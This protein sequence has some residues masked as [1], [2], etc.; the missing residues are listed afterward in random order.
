MK[1]DEGAL[2]LEIV[3]L[4][5]GVARAFLRHSPR[6]LRLTPASAAVLSERLKATGFSKI[7]VQDSR[8]GVVRKALTSLGWNV[9]RAMKPQL[10]RKCKTVSTFDLPIDEDLIDSDGRTPD[11]TNTSQ[12][13]GI[14]VDLGDRKAW[15]FYTDDGNAARVLSEKER[16]QGLLVANTTEDMF[17]AAECLVQYLAVTRKSWA[18]FSTDLGRFIRKFDPIEMWRL[19]LDRI[20]PFQ[21]GAA[22][23]L[24]AKNRRRTTR[25]VSEYYDESMIR[26]MLRLRK[27]ASDRNYSVSVNEG[28]FVITRLEGDVGLI[29]DIYVTPSKQG[30][31]LGEALLRAALTALAGRVTSCYLHSSYP[32]AKELY[33]KYGFRTVYTQ[34]GLR[35]DEIALTPPTTIQSR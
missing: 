27:Y 13:Q 11:V 2:S 25:L 29:Y 8:A 34:L 20:T 17:D 9:D 10:T 12:M 30:Q 32:R 15:A 26:A 3:P 6:G 31:G 5:E 21:Q 16:R 33:E 1:G 28:G 22:V 18:V 24:S 35:L 4:R 14:S 23:P 19:N 7:L